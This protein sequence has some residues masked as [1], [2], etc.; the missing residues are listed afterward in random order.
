MNCS[1]CEHFVGSIAEYVKVI[2]YIY[3]ASLT[4]ILIIFEEG[5]Y[6]LT[7]NKKIDLI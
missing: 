5:M 6:K 7:Q 4:A 1:T 3:V 2:I